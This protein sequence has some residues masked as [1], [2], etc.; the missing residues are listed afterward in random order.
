MN[1]KYFIKLRNDS[2]AKLAFYIS[3][4]YVSLGTYDL[5]LSDMQLSKFLDGISDGL[6]DKI[7]L[8][9][10][11]IGGMT[12]WILGS[13]VYNTKLWGWLGQILNLFIIW[14]ILYVLFKVIKSIRNKSLQ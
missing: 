1:N 14:L 4:F 3:L 9:S 13:F 11:I 5:L 10:N 8:P 7:L 2:E 6:D 12:W